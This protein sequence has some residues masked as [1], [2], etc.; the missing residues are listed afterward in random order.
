M[1]QNVESENIILILYISKE[2][3]YVDALSLRY[4]SAIIH[5]VNLVMLNNEASS[6]R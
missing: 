6:P 3:V 2:A 1:Y 5:R 4:V